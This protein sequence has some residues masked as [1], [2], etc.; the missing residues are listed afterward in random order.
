[1]FT[2]LIVKYYKLSIS[3]VTDVNDK[4]PLFDIDELLGS[5]TENSLPG[6]PVLR[7]IARDADAGVNGD[8]SYRLI[9]DDYE[10]FGRFAV[11]TRTGWISTLVSLDREDVSEYRFR[12]EAVDAGFPNALSSIVMVTVVVVDENDEA[13]TFSAERYTG[14]V[15]EDALPGTIILQLITSDRDQVCNHYG[16]NN[17]NNTAR[18]CHL[19]F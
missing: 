7:V 2:L 12:V 19:F 4:A 9:T 15:N 8:V 6:A 5:V 14:A 16:N 10:L 3:K 1:L 18:Q 17:N 13:P 11:D